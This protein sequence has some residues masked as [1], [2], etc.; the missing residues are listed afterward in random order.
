MRLGNRRRVQ[1][2]RARKEKETAVEARGVTPGG[3]GERRGP[4]LR[5][6]DARVRAAVAR[7]VG[8]VRHLRSGHVAAAAVTLLRPRRPVWPSHVSGP[9]QPASTRRASCGPHRTR[10]G[11]F[12][13]KAVRRRAG[14]RAKG[15]AERLA[16]VHWD[17]MRGGARGV[18]ERPPANGAS[19]SG[20]RAAR[21]RRPQRN[22][23]NGTRG[24]R[25]PRAQP[26]GPAGMQEAAAGRAVGGWS[27]GGGA[28]GKGRGAAPK[29]AL[30]RSLS[31]L[32]G[33][34]GQSAA[35]PPPDSDIAP[36]AHAR[37]HGRRE[38]RE[39]KTPSRG[40]GRERALSE[41]CVP[42]KRA[43]ERRASA[44]T[45]SAVRPRRHS[46]RNRTR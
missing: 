36:P 34:S 2:G 45:R 46:P 12:G 39:K 20:E 23:S 33:G 41:T 30:D 26:R 6:L 7:V 40:R 43:A 35:C 13:R 11:G 19:G 27:A 15:G 42:V 3:G 14:R 10:E 18:H 21:R 5:E 4:R 8:E 29:G 44:R 22:S 16:G 32:H 24:P 37:G 31:H 25:A 17:E 9:A 38:A 1:Q 28:A